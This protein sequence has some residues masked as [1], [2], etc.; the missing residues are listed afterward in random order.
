MEPNFN[1]QNRETQQNPSSQ[2]S[3]PAPQ[4]FQSPQPQQQEP[5]IQDKSAS[6]HTPDP[7]V[8]QQRKEKVLKILKSNYNWLT[9]IVLAVIV[10][11]AVKIRTANLP[12]LRDITTDTWTLGPD[13]DPFLFLRM[14]KYIIEHGSLFAVDTMRFVPLGFQTKNDLI[15]HPYL[16]AWFHKLAVIFG[17]ESANHSAVLYPV[18]MFALTV[19]AFFF[20]ARKI[21]LPSLGPK[22][23]NIV[24]L[25]AAFFLSVLPSILPRTIAGIPEKESAAFLFLFLAFYFF[26][27]SWQSKN[28]KSQIFLAIL[29]GISTAAMALI[30]GAYL[31]IFF[32][33]SLT[34]FIAF[35]LGKVTKNRIYAYIIWIIS[36]FIIMYPLSARYTIRGLTTSLNTGIAVF[37]LFIILTHLAVKKF[38]LKRYLNIPYLKKLPLPIIST[39]LAI[40]IS[41]LLLLVWIGPVFFTNQFENIVSNL[42]DPATSRLIQTVAENRQPFFVEWSG[43]FGPFVRGIPVF[44]WIFFSGSIFLFYKTVHMLSKK[45]RLYLTGSFALLLAGISLSRYDS[46]SIFNGSNTTSTLFYASGF[47]AFI[48]ASGFIYLKYHKEEKQ[49]LFKK[50]DTGLILLFIFFLLAVIAA[51]GTV[52]LIMMLVP[53]TS[54]IVGYFV[55]SIFNDAR[56]VNDKMAKTLVWLIVAIVII[57]TAF[58]GYQFHQGVSA[59]AAGF[60]PSIYTQQWQ[61]SMAWVREN[62]PQDAVFGHWWDYGYWVQSIGERATVLDGGNAMPGWNPLMGRHALTGTDNIA[63][64]EYLYVHETTHFLIDSTDI[65]KYSAFSTIGSDENLDRQS[66]IPSFVINRD[67]TIE[68]KNATTFFYQGGVTIDE[69][70]IFKEGDDEL[71]LPKGGAGIGAVSI[72]RDSSGKISQPNGIFIYQ[73]QQY[74]IPLRYAYDGELIDFQSGVEAGVFIMPLFQDGSGIQNAGALLY[75]SP[76]TVNSQLARLYLY[77][78]NNPYFKLV[79]SQDDFL[80]EQIKSQ[81]FDFTSD[82][83]FFNGVRGPIRIWEITYPDDIQ[84]REDYL[85]LEYLESIER[86]A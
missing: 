61:K 51:R 73:G 72:E 43:N 20:L 28:F 47:L 38:N 84:Y 16:M 65:G 18:F 52:R 14:S 34:V 39:I 40:A 19:I 24:G 9:Y 37:V 25:I 81:N 41:S 50:L 21:A 30:W 78:E 35:L 69:D 56:K 64:L 15:L 85:D 44:F 23:S 11:I 4:P 2:P 7:Q 75:L 10:Y 49:D 59:Q 66:F 62:T 58:A 74:N 26:I 17:S 8:I 3:T 48:I 32:T 55:V 57:G 60:A 67:A 22:K 71:F 13:L 45:E 31:F 27:S 83:V 36:A 77:K 53:P 76:R 29:A 63:A 82:F 1:S 68:T 33:I 42:V 5:L 54:I 46:S 6:L 70:I 80:V 79:N 86:D 12:R